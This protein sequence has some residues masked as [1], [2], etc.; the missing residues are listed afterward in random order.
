LATGYSI[1]GNAIQLSGDLSCSGLGGVSTFQPDL[2]LITN[3]TVAVG[4][5]SGLTLGGTVE[6]NGRNLRAQLDGWALFSGN[7]S[8]TGNVHKFGNGTLHL[9]GNCTFNDDCRAYEGTVRVDGVLSNATVAAYSGAT[10]AGEGVCNVISVAGT[11]SPGH[12]GPAI[13]RS[14]SHV[15]LDGNSAAGQLATYVCQL[16]GPDAGSGYDQLAL[17]GYLYIKDTVLNLS[18]GAP[19]G[20]GQRSP[21]SAMKA[22]GLTVIPFSVC[23]T[24]RCSP[25]MVTSFTS[26]IVASPAML[27]MSSSRCSMPRRIDRALGRGGMNAFWSTPA[28]W[29]GNAV[30]TAGKPLSFPPG[31]TRGLST[32]DLAPA[33]AFNGIYF[34]DTN[35]TL[36][37][38]AVS[39]NGGITNSVSGTNRIDL[40]LTLNAPQRFHIDG[41]VGHV[42]V[43]IVNGSINGAGGVIKSG[44]GLLILNGT[45]TCTGP[46]TISQGFV[47]MNGT[48]E[49]SP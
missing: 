1:S 3:A 26:P 36:R 4:A 35:Y 30:P 34:G 47:Q 22:D 31:A 9:T 6:L 2:S 40:G 29:S 32:N 15:W 17:S 20:L 37:G 23:R 33:T 27:V 11:L 44:V 8:G 10:L 43:L 38:A 24:I 19:L 13:L 28:N 39:L 16:N 49:N 14:R 25:P 46:T 18:I 48:L 12:N 45:N 7:I 21:S 41:Q 42:A 5:F